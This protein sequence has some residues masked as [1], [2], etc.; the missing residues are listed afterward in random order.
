MSFIAHWKTTTGFNTE[1]YPVT[2]GKKLNECTVDELTG[3]PMCGSI[4]PWGNVAFTAKS[5]D[6]AY[7][8][9]ISHIT[10]GVMF[11][12]P[13]TSSKSDVEVNEPA[14]TGDTAKIYRRSIFIAW[15]TNI[16]IPQHS[17][18]D[19]CSDDIY[20]VDNIVAPNKL[21]CNY[22]GVSG[23]GTGD[24]AA[25]TA[26]VCGYTLRHT[27]QK[28]QTAYA[29]APSQLVYTDE[30]DPNHPVTTTYNLG[31]AFVYIAGDNAFVVTDDHVGSF[32]F[33][34]Q[35]NNTSNQY[36]MLGGGSDYK[37]FISENDYRFF[38][39]MNPNGTNREATLAEIFPGCFA[40]PVPNPAVFVNTY[41]TTTVTTI[42]IPT[43]KIRFLLSN[44][45]IGGS[46]ASRSLNF[47]LG[48]DTAVEARLQQI[49]RA[50]TYFVFNG[51]VWKPIIVGGVVVG[52]GTPDKVSE[53][54]TYTDLNHPVPTGPGGGGGGSD[55][56]D[57]S[58]NVSDS[59]P[60]CNSGMFA[61][62][63]AINYNALTII[64]NYING[65]DAN[66]D[67][68]GEGDKWYEKVWDAVKDLTGFN[69]QY[70]P[71]QSLMSLTIYP[72]IINAGTVMDIYLNSPGGKLQT[73]AQGNFLGSHPIATYSLGSRSINT[74]MNGKGFPFLDYSCTA[75]IYVP[76]CGFAPLD[77]QFIM[78]GE[79]Y[80][81]F[82]VDYT[83]GECC[84]R[85]YCSK[86][87][88]DT[89]VALLGGK[90]GAELPITSNGWATYKN[91]LA[92]LNARNF[93]SLISGGGQIASAFAPGAR[94]REPRVTQGGEGLRY[95]NSPNVASL[96]GGASTMVNAMAGYIQSENLGKHNFTT[97]IGGF[98]GLASWHNP[99]VPFIKIQRPN[100]RKPTNYGNTVG[101]PRVETTSLQKG[102]N[103]VINPDLSAL[104]SDLTASEL[105]EV[106]AL[107]TSSVYIK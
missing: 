46:V 27:C 50:G 60:F 32:G 25:V 95:S 21:V 33:R 52:Y 15:K 78:G 72:F 51:E 91:E 5:S 61:R 64:A 94:V 19:T 92:T 87:G 12:E 41:Y 34:Y 85:V 30:S 77:I 56:D 20:I 23:L 36:N 88:T 81:N 68:L 93:S 58:D 89:I 55:E 75:E 26:R 71:M 79:V 28:G 1:D 31:V 8:S 38:I 103:V 69:V 37:S 17:I 86:N 105:S 22:T 3:H 43:I 11:K 24:G 98:G 90:V 97:A 66:G 101:I 65:L 63:Y 96:Y 106:Y 80:V 35:N 76:F 13:I 9:V 70:D 67:P 45:S 100:P 107:L 40:N 16:S 53:I 6:L 42:H 2:I 29:S 83:T 39:G 49:C 48:A 104:T 99:T 4:S 59:D 74:V 102:L 7:S 62:L 73:G 44:S 18:D 84:A 82:T 57:D 10:G 54:D 47:G 14:N